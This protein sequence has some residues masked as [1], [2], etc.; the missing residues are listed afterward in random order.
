MT[1]V[2]MFDIHATIPEVLETMKTDV[3]TQATKPV[4]EVPN[5][6]EHGWEGDEGG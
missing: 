6:L 2:E 1:A 3:W 5:P 4:I